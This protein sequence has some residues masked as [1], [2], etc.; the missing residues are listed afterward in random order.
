M[1]DHIVKQQVGFTPTMEN[2]TGVFYL[3]HHA[4]KKECHWKIKWRIVFD[5]SSS[6]GNGRSLNNVLEM[7]PN[8][9]LEVLVILLRFHTCPVAVIGDV[10]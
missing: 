2:S 8:L 6:K 7:D 9:L 4:V 5:A 3:P 10:Q 1:L